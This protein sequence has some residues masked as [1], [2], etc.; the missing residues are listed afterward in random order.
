MYGGED[1]AYTVLVA[2]PEGRMHLEDVVIHDM[3]ILKWILKK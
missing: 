1:N 3:I 2:T